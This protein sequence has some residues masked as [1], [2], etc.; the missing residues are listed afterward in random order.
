MQFAFSA[1]AQTRGQI[2]AKV[3]LQADTALRLHPGHSD[4]GDAELRIDACNL[5][6]TGGS[7]SWS[8]DDRISL[9]DRVVPSQIPDIYI[10]RAP[11]GV[12]QRWMYFY[13]N[14]LDG[15]Q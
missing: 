10:G 9:L 3:D 8:A 13:N 5:L 11:F 12:R 7:Y 4:A 6:R 15:Q 14:L 1:D 2:W